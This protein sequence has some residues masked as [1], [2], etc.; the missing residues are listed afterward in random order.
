M[1]LKAAFRSA[2]A[3]SA[4]ALALGV[5]GV[6]SAPSAAYRVNGAPY[7]TTAK[8]HYTIIRRALHAVNGRLCIARR[9]IMTT[10]VS[11]VASWYGAAISRQTDRKRRNL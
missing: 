8:A 3:S 7:V 9:W 4:T 5:S 1:F 2:P 10:K 6:T 11:G